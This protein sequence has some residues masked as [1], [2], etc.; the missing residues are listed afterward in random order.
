MPRILQHFI[1]LLT[2]SVSVLVIY[3]QTLHYSFH[4]DDYFFITENLKIRD[5][6]NVQDIWNSL[7][8]PSRFI[9]MYSFALNYHFHQLDVFGYHIVNIMIHIINGL[10]VR[11]LVLL[12]L[13]TRKFDYREWLATSTAVLFVCHPMNTQAVTYI[14]QRFASLGS[15]FYLLSLCFYIQGRLTAG[16]H[17]NIIFTFSFLSVV[18]GM[19]TKQIVLTLPICVLLYEYCFLDL[20]KKWKPRWPQIMI[21]LGLLVLI[22]TLHSWDFSRLF[23]ARIESRSHEGDI[24][25][26][27]TYMLT[28]FRVI[29]LY[30]SK[31]FCPVGQTLD[32]DFPL[33]TR[34]WDAKVIGGMIFIFSTLIAA[35]VN[36]RRRPIMAFG[37][38]WFFITLS[39]E[40]TI[41]PIYQVIFEHRCYLPSI[42]LL[43]AVNFFLW[44]IFKSR[45]KYAICIFLIIV[46][47]GWTAYQRN[48][49][50]ENETTLWKDIKQKAPRK[51]RPYI[52]LGASY[53]MKGEYD[54]ALNE[55]NQALKMKQDDYKIFHNRGIVYEMKGELEKAKNDYTRAIQLSAGSAPS[56]MNRAGVLV[57][58]KQYDAALIDYNKAIEWDKDY[59]DAYSGRANLYYMAGRYQ[60]ALED[61]MTAK[62]LGSPVD[63]N[64]IEQVKRM[65][66]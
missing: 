61:L 17:K 43:F 59:G 15:M 45:R 51:V 49:V 35:I 24:I 63:E 44:E 27:Y 32:Y 50:W 20:G 11:W 22:P 23:D 14:T 56:Y 39:I 25:T 60:Q 30:I 46:V 53:I 42:G 29:P 6:Q 33:S 1:A 18:L 57:Q 47:L 26:S 66:Q 64:D 54:L 3:A 37:I 4:F 21:F 31:M 8:K 41:I 52:H 62:K 12:T 40:S 55:F 7:G 28:Q 58:L 34:F 48:R 5:I 9:G 13:T 38:L 2:I 10:L 65:I 19:F 36:L 16:K